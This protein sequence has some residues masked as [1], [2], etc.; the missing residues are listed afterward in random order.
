MLLLV[1]LIVV[2]VGIVFSVSPGR[3]RCGIDN[4]DEVSLWYLC[5]Q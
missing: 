1:L 2:L 5:G 3:D 4:L